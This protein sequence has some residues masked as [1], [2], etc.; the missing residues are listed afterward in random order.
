MAGQ[1]EQ[2]LD[3]RLAALDQ[4]VAWLSS[5]MLDLHKEIQEV[6]RLLED[7]MDT[8]E[9]EE[10]PSVEITPQLPASVAAPSAAAPTQQSVGATLAGGGA[11][12]NWVA[13]NGTGSSV[14]QNNMSRVEETPQ[15]ESRPANDVTKYLFT[16]SCGTPK[17]HGM[18]DKRINEKNGLYQFLYASHERCVDC[19]KKSLNKRY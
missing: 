6:K 4:K 8:D 3:M 15:Q 1:W 11:P 10:D 9:G 14:G 7:R 12:W 19:M 2:K 13:V 18:D 5:T 17:F 16:P